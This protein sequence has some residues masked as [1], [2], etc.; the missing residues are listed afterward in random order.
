MAEEQVDCW[1]WDIANQVW[2][3]IQVDVNGRVVVTT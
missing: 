1:G 3:K 2:V